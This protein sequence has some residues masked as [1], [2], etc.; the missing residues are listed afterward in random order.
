MGRASNTKI[1]NETQ[2]L[3][4]TLH[5][6]DLIDVHRAFNPESANTHSSQVYREHSPEQILCWATKQTYANSR[7]LKAY[8]ASSLTTTL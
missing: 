6:M 8:Q 2:A 3:K 1:N 5:Q 7:K 4:D